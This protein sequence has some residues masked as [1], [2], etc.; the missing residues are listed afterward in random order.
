MKTAILFCFVLLFFIPSIAQVEGGIHE[1]LAKLY[2]KERYEDCMFR[3]VDLTYKDK[4]R[5]DPEPYLYAA[6]SYYQLSLSDDPGIVEDYPKALNN[7]VKYLL[8]FKRKDKDNALYAQNEG[9]ITTI[10]AAYF[11]ESNTFFKLEDYKKAA[12]NFKQL[13]K[14]YDE[15]PDLLFLQA[16]CDALAEKSTAR[17]SL[18]QTIPVL[19]NLQNEGKLKVRREVKE[20]FSDAFI[21]YADQ[22]YA[23]EMPDSAFATLDLGL[24]LL[25][26]NINIL[27]KKDSLKN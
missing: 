22:L 14:W 12:F 3:A 16:I 9:N 15:S 8:K 10:L 1:K 2:E 13:A 6:M 21:R 27:S 25:P 23:S 5:S 17:L 7:A 4:Y 19:L 11:E 20:T 18:D 26:G 24:K